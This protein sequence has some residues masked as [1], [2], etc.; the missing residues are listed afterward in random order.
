[1]SRN[2]LRTGSNDPSRG[3]G[4]PPNEVDSREN[5]E[6]LR[7]R[8]ATIRGVQKRVLIVDDHQPFRAIARELLESAG[9]IVAGEAADAAGA[10]A[11]VAA[12][13]PDAVRLDVQLPD[14]DGFAVATELAAADGPTVVLIS[15]R[16]ADDYG[17][18]VAA[19]GARGFIPKS[20]LSV[21]T[22]AALLD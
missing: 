8:C 3:S 5:P 7:E 17:R 16:D 20:K 11:A 13:A 18:R 1:M 10:L 14:R 15:S 22:V 19:C 9:Y 2:R 21:A 6:P 12:H 4:I